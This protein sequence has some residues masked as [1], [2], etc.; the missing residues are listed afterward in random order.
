MVMPE[1]FF[2]RPEMYYARI[3]RPEDMLLKFALCCY[4]SYRGVV[5][6]DHEKCENNTPE[7]V[8]GAASHTRVRLK[9]RRLYLCWRCLT[10]N[11]HQT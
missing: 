11:I 4:N 1:S 2:T 9:A 10:H 5:F 7:R 8:A 6:E 3:L